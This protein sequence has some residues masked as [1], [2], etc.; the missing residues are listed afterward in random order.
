VRSL[1]P[2]HVLG[3]RYEIVRVIGRGGQSVVY[4]ARDRI[5]GDEVAVKVVHGAVGDPD[6]ME[7]VFREA[8]TMAELHGT[9]AVRILHQ[10]RTDDGD[11]ALVMELLEGRDLEVHLSEL[12]SRGERPSLPFIE[13]T[14]APVVDTLAV[15]H[16]R[17]FVHRDVKAENVF[18]VQDGG[19][20]LVDFGFVKLL[21]APTITASESLAGSPCYIAP[22]VW[23]NGA[24]AAEPRSDVYGLA[25]VLYRTLAGRVPFEGSPIEIMHAATRGPRPR[26]SLERADLSP[27][28]DAWVEQAL[29][30][31]PD[32]RFASVRATFRALLE[33]FPAR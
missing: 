23:E 15:A 25:V 18:L 21:R 2:G 20:R 9:A 8:R 28:V 32:E 22:E 6:A 27:D 4:R 33:C 7:R 26:L 19:V 12:E 5:D 10:V 17:G 30:A 1:P 3:G 24:V 13:R 11:L 29:A 14:F 31:R 16:A